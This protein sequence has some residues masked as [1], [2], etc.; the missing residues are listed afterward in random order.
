MKVTAR[1]VFG[2]LAIGVAAVGLTGCGPS[3][4]EKVETVATALKQANPDDTR[5]VAYANY[6]YRSGKSTY[7]ER[8][9]TLVQDEAACRNHGE[10]HAMRAAKYANGQD[11]SLTCLTLD[12]KVAGRFNCVINPAGKPV[13]GAP[14]STATRQLTFPSLD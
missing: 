11:V 1:Q 13:C 8:H 4:T 5:L 7:T 14:G 2:A 9:V 6:D 12:G 3:E 10:F